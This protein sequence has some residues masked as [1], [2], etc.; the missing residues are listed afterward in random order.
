MD[1]MWHYIYIYIY[2]CQSCGIIY[3]THHEEVLE[4]IKSLPLIKII[5]GAGMNH[6]SFCKL[7]LGGYR[8]SMI[9]SINIKSISNNNKK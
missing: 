6:Y 5:F 7:E 9:Q 8:I 3:C 1:E 4:I 2:I